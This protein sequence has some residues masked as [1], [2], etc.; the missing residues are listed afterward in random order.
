[1]GRISGADAVATAILFLH[2]STAFGVVPLGWGFQGSSLGKLHS[3]RRISLCGSG[4]LCRYANLRGAKRPR[5][6]PADHR[7]AS[8]FA[9]PGIRFEEGIRLC[10]IGLVG[11]GCARCFMVSSM[12]AKN[13]QRAWCL[14]RRYQC[15]S[16]IGSAP[17]YWSRSWFCMINNKQCYRSFPPPVRSHDRSRRRCQ[18]CHGRRRSCRE[19]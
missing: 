16:M 4:G 18:C 5:F 6:G 19:R 10:R 8:C 9:S 7:C 13:N 14:R 11:S 3:A 12:T 17:T 15:W 1:M 2:R